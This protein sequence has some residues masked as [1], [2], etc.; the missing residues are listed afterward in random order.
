MPTFALNFSRPG[1][2][3]VAQYYN[4]IRLGKDGYRRIH[5]ACQDVALYLSSELEKLG[6]FTILHPG[7]TLPVLSWRISAD[8]NVNYS[9]FDLSER[10]RMSGW[11]VPA[12][13]L[14]ENLT[15]IAIMRIVVKEGMSMELA[16]LLL[17]DLRRAI[18]HFSR[19]GGGQ[20]E[21]LSGFHH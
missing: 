10:L 1:N 8:A 12:Y 11:Q 2:Q 4:F 15:D 14:P 7:D 5:Q 9:V 18:D 6:V 3:V 13:T 16:D 19:V 20:A 21:A 17:A